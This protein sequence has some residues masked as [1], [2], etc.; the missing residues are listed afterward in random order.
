[1]LHLLAQTTEAAAH[2]NAFAPNAL[3]SLLYG[4]VE[5][6]TEFLPVSSTAHLRIVEAFSGTSLDSGYWKMYSVVIQ[7]GA[8]L[9]VPLL[10]K[11]RILKFLHTFPKG[12]SGNKTIWNH[13]LSLVMIGFFVTAGPCYLADKFIG[14]NLESLLVMGLSLVVG[15]IIMWVV[16]FL[17]RNPKVTRMEDMGILDAVWIGAVQILSAV[18]PG[19]SRSMSTIAAGQVFSLS[20]AT[21]LEYSFFLSIPTMIAATGYKLLQALVHHKTPAEAAAYNPPE[22]QWIILAIGF[23]VSFIVALGV[24]A[25]FINWVRTRGF[26]PFAIYRILFGGAILIWLFTGGH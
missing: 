18:F 5:G 11:N 24:N 12:E 20:R 9:S 26:I 6:L 19:T 4:I 23:V 25:W 7:L 14:K 15:G 8:I 2:S 22:H 1:M 13:P 17:C 16:D 21:A 10:F 3:L